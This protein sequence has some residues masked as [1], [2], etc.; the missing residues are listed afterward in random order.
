MDFVK[1]LRPRPSKIF[2]MH[3]EEQKCEDL[4]DILRKITNA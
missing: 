2:T 3:G 1:D 4:A